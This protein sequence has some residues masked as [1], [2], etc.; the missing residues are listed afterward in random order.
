MLLPAKQ[1]F[2]LVSR[3]L[4]HRQ[5]AVISE[6]ARHTRSEAREGCGCAQG[7]KD[8]EE[9]QQTPPARGASQHAL[10]ICMQNR[11]KTES[12]ARDARSLCDDEAAIVQ[13][14]RTARGGASAHRLASELNQQAA[15]PGKIYAASGPVPRSAANAG[16][17]SATEIAA[18]LRARLQ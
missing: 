2:S 10:L 12:V 15:E 1:C 7:D 17:C 18:E 4:Q 8:S 16:C 14:Q 3:P 13:L 6:R 11:T 9:E 5:Q